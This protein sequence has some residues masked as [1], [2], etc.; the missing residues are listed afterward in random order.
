M[1]EFH[2]IDHPG[3][4]QKFQEEG[5]AVVN[6]VIS[7][8]SAVDLRHI[9][10]LKI[11]S[12]AKQLGCLK[13]DYLTSVS[14]W[15]DPSPVTADVSRVVLEKLRRA[16]QKFI[17]KPVRLKKMNIIC[18][19][20]HCTGSVPYH[21]DISYSPQDPYEFSMWVALNDISGDSSPLEVIPESH[22]L[23]LKP[24]VDF[25][26]PNYEPET[27]LK[28]RAKKLMLEAGDAVF[29]DSRL[30]H[31]SGENKDLSSRYALAM[32]W[33]REGWEFNE[34][35]PAIEPNFF[36]LWTSGKMTEDLLAEGLS[37]L[38]KRSEADFIKLLDLWM[39]CIQESSLPFLVDIS[40]ALASFKDLKILHLAHIHH[41]GGD[42]VGTVYR[43]FWEKFLSPLNDYISAIEMKRNLQ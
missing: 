36:G 30:W 2:T 15:V 23:P 40:S 14:R 11:D 13:E 42:A 17:K 33:S 24:A 10:E 25:W 22:L 38:F 28:M 1:S 20:A 32:R 29:F 21:Q 39:H 8:K 37:V 26:S 16:A 4:T 35:I 27:S 18:K 5:Y 7:K 9:I 31:G 3:I 41:N 43:N 34:P 19:N 6:Q 12:C